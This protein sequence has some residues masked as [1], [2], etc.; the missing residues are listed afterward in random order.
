MRETQDTEVV[1]FEY[2]WY[3]IEGGVH[4]IPLFRE[5]E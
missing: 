3:D 1:S 4:A 2:V 5:K